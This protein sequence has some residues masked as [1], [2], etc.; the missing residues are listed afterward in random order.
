MPW[1][2]L[3]GV[4]WGLWG[5]WVYVMCLGGLPDTLPDPSQIT[6][7][8]P[9]SLPDPSQIHTRQPQTPTRPFPYPYQ[10]PV[11][12]SQTPETPTSAITAQFAKSSVSD[13]PADHLPAQVTILSATA[14]LLGARSCPAYYIK[15]EAFTVRLILRDK[16]CTE[17][18]L[19]YF[20]MTLRSLFSL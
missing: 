4:W 11:D 7:D 9:R 2:G 20:G 6:P 12:P 17:V 14:K 5:V 1:G 3:R 18:F 15:P 16:Y 13:F 10:A 19:L 8:T